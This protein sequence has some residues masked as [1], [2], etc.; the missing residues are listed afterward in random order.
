MAPRRVI[1]SVA[2]QV[3]DLV[4][5]MEALAPVRYAEPWDNVGLLIGDPEATVHRVLLAVDYTHAVAAEAAAEGCDAVVAYHPVIF[6]DLKRVLA[7]SSVW[8]A[9]RAG[10]AVY[11]PHTALDI[12]PGGTN[13]VLAEALGLTRCRPLRPLPGRGGENL[14]L[15][16]G[17][18]GTLVPVA[19]A[20]LVDQVKNALGLTHLLVAG[21]TEGE[22]RTGAV[23]AGACGDLL[24]DVIAQGVDVYLTGELRHHDA[25]TAAAAGVTVLCTLHSNSERAALVRV[26]H[27][28]STALPGLPVVLSRTDRDPFSV[29]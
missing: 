8:D 15:G 29:R 7:G 20:T 26:R 17:R 12:A 13:D 9:V 19:R 10:V 11:S 6:K 5:A 14:G 3:H 1:P 18:V 25:L 23:G 24:H 21:P 2:M 16:M 4:A 28:L 27:G 22:A